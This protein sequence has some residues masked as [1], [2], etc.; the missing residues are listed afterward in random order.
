LAPATSENSISIR[1]PI[2]V[3]TICGA[4][5]GQEIPVGLI[6]GRNVRGAPEPADE[7]AIDLGLDTDAA[8]GA[9]GD[10]PAHPTTSALA[11]NS[12]INDDF[13]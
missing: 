5:D 12:N 1:K 3:T 2:E 10:E 9:S 13:I 8:S 7:A 4:S 6:G 11:D